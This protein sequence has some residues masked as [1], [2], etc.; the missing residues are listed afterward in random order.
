MAFDITSVKDLTGQTLYHP[1]KKAFLLWKS[2]CGDYKSQ[3][4][5]K[6][7]IQMPGLML[8]RGDSIH[9]NAMNH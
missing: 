6:N 8:S 2:D 1:F 5:L 4:E 3:R 7:V 9:C